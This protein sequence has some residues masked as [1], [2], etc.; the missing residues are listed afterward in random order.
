MFLYAFLYYIHENSGL[1]ALKCQKYLR[2]KLNLI[3]YINKYILL[4]KIVEIYKWKHEERK[5]GR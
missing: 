3:K 2:I 4:N 5:N 1:K